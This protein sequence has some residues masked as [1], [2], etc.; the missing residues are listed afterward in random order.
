LLRIDLSNNTVAQ[1]FKGQSDWVLAA[2][3]QP[4]VAKENENGNRLVASS[5]F[6]GEVKLWKIA[7]STLVQS[8]TAKP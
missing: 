2:C 8:W 6:D 4:R 3:H 7:D 5:T 1:E